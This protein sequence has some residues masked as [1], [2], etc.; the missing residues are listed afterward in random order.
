MMGST[1]GLVG[2]RSG[3]DVAFVGADGAL[4]SVL[5]PALAAHPV[6]LRSPDLTDRSPLPELA[7]RRVV[8][9]AAGPRVHPGL[10]W[11]DYLREHVGTT[12]R[13]ASSL[14]PGSHLVLV[15]SAAI[16]GSGRGSVDAATAPDPASFPAP[17]YAWAKLAAE[18]TARAICAERGVALTV[19]RPSIIY[20][21]G[22]GGVLIALRDLAR[23]GV[24]FVLDPPAARQ[25]LL[26]LRLFEQVLR[27][28]IASPPPARPATH[29]VADP[30]VLTTAD[31]NAAIERAGR[32][33]AVIPAPVSWVAK[34][35]R[36]WQSAGDRRAPGPFAVASMLVL[37][38]AYDAGATLAA[39]GVDAAPFGR[40][41]FDEF[42][43]A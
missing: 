13:V 34:A 7:G 39:L 9:H 4:G 27:A 29:V 30:F 11:G 26:H 24:R 36:A 16:Y 28:V 33:A 42:M 41:L 40:S 5:A 18:H 38:N 1:D 19:L 2:G 31:V 10:G 21:P 15:S 12:T 14:A 35:T 17:D 6:R 25:H 3:A 23:R 32:R 22:A 8:I 43:S 37:D 20:G